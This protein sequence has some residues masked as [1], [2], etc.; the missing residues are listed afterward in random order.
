MKVRAS[1]LRKSRATLRIFHMLVKSSS[2]PSWLPFRGPASLIS[3]RRSTRSFSSMSSVFVIPIH[4]S[5]LL[6]HLLYHSFSQQ[7]SPCTS[8][9]ISHQSLSCSVAWSVD[10]GAFLPMITRSGNGCAPLK[11]GIGR[12]PLHDT[13]FNPPTP[14]LRNTTQ[15]MKGW[16]TRRYK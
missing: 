14:N 7:R 15:M 10:A 3:G 8:F 12:I 6:S 16:A 9:P 1:N 13:T 5:I 2:V 4:L 11:G